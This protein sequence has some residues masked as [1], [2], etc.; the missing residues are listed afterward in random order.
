M[1]VGFVGAGP[2]IEAVRAAL[3]DVDVGET[4][5]TAALDDGTSFVVVSGD[6][7]D[8]VFER[9]NRRAVERERPWIAVEGNGIGGRDVPG[10]E[11]AVSG[12]TPETACFE[13]LRT[14]VKAAADSPARDG[15]EHDTDASSGGGPA[16]IRLAGAIA[17]RELS[18]IVRGDSSPL[19]GGVIEVP[20]ASRTVLPV[21]GCEVCDPS[22]ERGVDGTPTGAVAA[23]E[24]ETRSLEAALARAERALDER[25]GIVTSTGEA[26]SFP[27]PYYLATVAETSEF[28]DATAAPQAAGVAADWNE[29]FMKAMG[30]G[31][32][33]YCAGVYRTAKFERA[34]P[35]A[36]EDALSPDRFVRPAGG[37]LRSEPITWTQGWN[38]RTGESVSIPAEFV[39]FPPP[40]RRFRPSITTGL[41]LGNSA[42][43]A[44]LSGLYEV[45]ERDATML[46][47]YS[48]YEPLGLTVTD[49]VFEELARR[50]RSEDL[51]VT[52]LLVTQDVDVPVVTVAVHRE[53]TW[54]QFAVGSGANLDP[55]A[56]ARSAL[57]EAL[58]NWMELR[59]IGQED[60]T[61]ASGW[62][63]R[64]ATFPEAA[65]AFVDVD[66]SVPAS[67]VGPER[68]P[69]GKRALETLVERVYAVGLTPYAAWLTPRDVRSIGFEA[70]RIVVPEAQPLFTGRPYFGERADRVPRDLGFEPRPE[71]EP[72]PYP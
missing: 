59:S 69:T 4:S 47:W 41:G 39:H 49:D 7:G 52:A 61:E 66:S 38:L 45:V 5:T 64:Y 13:C 27:A 25:V 21:P 16:S 30:E 19:L 11:A 43:E 62:I 63:G 1:T 70:V 8:D 35:T 65:K 31:L 46:A 9:V 57:C 32:E 17:G 67:S 28:S 71:R 34:R 10:V 23:L 33:R 24:H 42:V 55:T 72:H 48:T 12:F 20:Y 26:E 37:D 58:Q 22:M 36:I 56:A 40:E 29:A 54:P 6:A 14:R 50:A 68:P 51:E 44:A 53:G 18:R 60:A 3:A 15:P 2:A